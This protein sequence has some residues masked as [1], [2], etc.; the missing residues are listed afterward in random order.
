MRDLFIGV[1]GIVILTVL[2]H[3]AA[4]RAVFGPDVYPAPPQ[5]EAVRNGDDARMFA[6]RADAAVE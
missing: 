3:C 1:V 6:H 4:E 2:A 5:D